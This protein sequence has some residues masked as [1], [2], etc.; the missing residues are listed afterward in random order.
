MLT[1]WTCAC[2]FRNREV[3]S[4]CGGSG[5]L[6]CKAS[7]PGSR[8]GL[9]GDT[10]TDGDPMRLNE[11]PARCAKTLRILT[12]NVWFSPIDREIRM[13]ALAA[14]LESVD[15]DVI[16]LQEVTSTILELLMGH[17]SSE[18]QVFKQE[19]AHVE[20]LYFFEANYFTCLLVKRTLQVEE[21]ACFRFSITAMARGLQLVVFSMKIEDEGMQTPE[22][23]YHKIIVAT[24]HLESAVASRSGQDTR[25]HQ[26]S[27]GQVGQ[28]IF[29]CML[30]HCNEQ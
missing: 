22:R 30:L 18:W 4:A 10:D 21:A 5:P 14:I 6:G 17:L 20:D 13:A 2:G 26:L 3:N 29:H 1:G 25:A 28:F 8:P 16:A 15:A 11:V 7:R 9:L 19:P 23:S 24:S 12:Y 27:E